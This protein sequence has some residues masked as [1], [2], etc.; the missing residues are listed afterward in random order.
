MGVRVRDEFKHETVLMEE[1]ER[2]PLTRKEG[3]CAE[4]TGQERTEV[5]IVPNWMVYP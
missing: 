1:S 5:D 4:D 3:E 2:R